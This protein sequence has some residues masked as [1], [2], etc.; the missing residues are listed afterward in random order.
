MVKNVTKLPDKVELIGRLTSVGNAFHHVLVP[1]AWLEV[2]A[3]KDLTFNP[4]PDPA[5]VMV[6][7]DNRMKMNW[8]TLMTL[9][10]LWM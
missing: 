4:S 9:V 2:R 1:Q 3:D 6:D 7:K 5:T 8:L 10:L